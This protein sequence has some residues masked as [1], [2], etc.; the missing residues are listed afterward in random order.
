ME[1]LTPL[2]KVAFLGDYVPRQCGIA[3]FTAD[4]RKAINERYTDLQC[5]VVAVTDRPEGYDYPPEV[6]FEIPERDLP[7]Y[8]RAAD[9]L[10]LGNADVVCVQHEFG[11]YGGVAARISSP[12]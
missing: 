3:T 12:R 5:P 10:N 6:R 4:I 8:R 7:A 1:S 2:R 9:F 11:I